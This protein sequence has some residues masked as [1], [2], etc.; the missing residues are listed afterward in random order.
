MTALAAARSNLEGPVFY[1]QGYKAKATK[2][3]YNGALCMLDTGGYLIPAG[4]TAGCRV[5]GIIELANSISKDTTGLSDGDYV[6]SVKSGVFSLAAG[7]TTDLPTIADL[8]KPVY[9]LD[10]QTISRLPGSGRP[11]VGILQKIDG[12]KFYV[13]VGLGAGSGAPANNNDGFGTAWQGPGSSE[14]F[15]SPGALSVNTEVSLLTVDG[16]DAITLA[17]GLFKGQRKIVTVVAG[18]NTPIGTITPATPSGFATVTALGAVGDSV[19]LIWN[20]A[21]WLLGPS[22]GCTFT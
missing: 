5:V 15:S 6:A 11:V 12:A 4:T 2:V 20:G 22:F 9:A 13:A 7:T 18:T 1:T 10:D 14:A 21:A 16:T 3:F 8:G 19:E 17:D